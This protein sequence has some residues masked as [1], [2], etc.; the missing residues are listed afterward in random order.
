MTYASATDLDDAYG[1]SEML[2]LSDRDGDGFA[3]AAVVAA[4]LARA[5][6]LIDGYLATRYALPLTPPYPPVVVAIACELARYWLFDDAAP[7]RVK[8]GYDQAIAWL[9]DVSA[10]RA[11][12]MLPAAGEESL[13]GSPSW[14]APD[15]L[16]TAATLSGF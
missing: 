11:A 3:D 1:E 4:V 10:G 12:L 5:D 13:T 14:E 2:Q 15:R 6:S 8:D 7:D 16:F 9:K